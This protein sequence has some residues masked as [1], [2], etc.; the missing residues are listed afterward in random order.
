MADEKKT[1]VETQPDD[2]PF[3][4]RWSQRKTE[5]RAQEMAPQPAVAMEP[6]PA[7]LPTIESVNL[8][9]GIAPFFKQ[10]AD[11]SL[12][13]LALKK[14]LA[15]PH[16]NIMDGLDIY[17]DDYGKADPIPESMMKSIRH[18]RQFVMTPEEISQLEA[19][20]SAAELKAKQAL[21]AKADISHD[22]S[23]FQNSL[24]KNDSKESN[25]HR[26]I[27]GKDKT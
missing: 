7:P 8:E 12:R 27:V 6:K 4:S 5:V 13:R 16:F 21:L 25:T 10:Q 3:L 22:E 23:E 1:D 11:E 14:L 24:D 9:S 15:D 18:A 20:E 17:I 2:K 26:E 19:Q